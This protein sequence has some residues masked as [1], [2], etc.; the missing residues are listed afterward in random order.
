MSGFDEPEV[1]IPSHRRAGVRR[2]ASGR[3]CQYVGT[4]YERPRLRLI[5]SRRPAAGPFGMHPLLPSTLAFAAL[6][7]TALAIAAVVDAANAVART[8]LTISAQFRTARLR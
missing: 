2:G 6:S 3:R 1:R 7:A 8:A 5:S 4:P